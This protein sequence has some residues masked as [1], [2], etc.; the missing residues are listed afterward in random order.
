MRWRSLPIRMQRDSTNAWA[1]RRSVRSMRRWRVSQ[2]NC[3]VWK[4]NLSHLVTRVQPTKTHKSHEITCDLCVLFC[5]SCA[6]YRSAGQASTELSVV[7]HSSATRS[8]VT[9]TA[10]ADHCAAADHSAEVD[11]SVAV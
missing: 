5:A 3:H 4:S 1:R 2:E 8:S 9:R 6:S 11:H 10:A 7:I